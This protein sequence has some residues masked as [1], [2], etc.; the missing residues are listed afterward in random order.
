MLD[1]STFLPASFSFSPQDPTDTS[2]FAWISHFL[3]GVCIRALV[4]VPNTHQ[5]LTLVSIRKRDRNGNTDKEYKWGNQNTS[6]GEWE[7]DVCGENGDEYMR[8]ENWE[9]SG[10]RQGP[11]KEKEQKGIK[12]WI[13]LTCRN[14]DKW[15]HSNCKTRASGLLSLPKAIFFIYCIYL[16]NVIF[17]ISFNGAVV[18]VKCVGGRGVCAIPFRLCVDLLLHLGMEPCLLP[19]TPPPLYLKKKLT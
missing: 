9:N 19:N 12:L 14:E 17:Q 16:S 10:W 8:R 11:P 15:R 18:P 13:I 5:T 2:L 7:R 1:L 4:L 6:T 3:F